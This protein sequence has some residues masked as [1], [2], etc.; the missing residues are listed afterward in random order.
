[1]ILDE[2]LNSLAQHVLNTILRV[3]PVIFKPNLPNA[4]PQGCGIYLR[5]NDD[6]YLITAGHLLNVKDWLELAIIGGYNNLVNLN[7]TLMTTHKKFETNNPI[8]F[9]L[10]KFSER[11]NKHLRGGSFAFCN[12]S[13]VIVNHKV[14]QN[15][16]YLISGYPVTGIKKK[17]GTS[18]YHPEPVKMTTFP[19]ELKKYDEYGVNPDHFILLHYQRKVAPFGSKEKRIMKELQGISGSGLWYVPNWN[20]RTNDG[21]PKFHLV[22]IMIENHKDKGYLKALRIDFVTETIKQQFIDSA[23]EQTNFVF[24]SDF[25]GL[26]ARKID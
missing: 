16:Y 6:L 17:S 11:Q 10:F 24:G 2:K 15:G 19:L 23:F 18:D 7:G 4:N 25:K 14:E 8:D 3:T 21:T 22:G 9:A 12:P 20:D 13:N 5:I 26:Q 1:M